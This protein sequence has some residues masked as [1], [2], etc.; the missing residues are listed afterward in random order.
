M[1][2]G[3]SRRYAHDSF[4]RHVN[5][6]VISQERR[7]LRCLCGL[8]V[9]LVWISLASAEEKPPVELSPSDAIHRY[10]S[11]PERTSRG[12]WLRPFPPHAARFTG[13]S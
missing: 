7:M 2:S 4:R 11:R 8:L 12:S 3:N 1:A 6:A 9:S 13:W 10:V 5:A